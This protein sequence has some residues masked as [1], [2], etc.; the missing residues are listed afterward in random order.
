MQEF[1]T[2]PTSIISELPD[3]KRLAMIDIF[4][5]ADENGHVKVSERE[6]MN[7]WKWGNT[8]VRNFLEYLKE[9]S[10]CKSVT[11]QSQ[12]TLIL[13]NTDFIGIS[14]SRN[15]AET[16]QKQ[17]T[18]KE[19]D[20]EIYKRII[21]HLNDVCGTNYKPTNKTTKEHI[22][23][24]LADGFS[25]ED[26][27]TVIDKKSKEWKNTS[28]ERYLRPQTLFSNK[29]ESY[30]NQK[31]VEDNPKNK[32]NNFS[33]REYNEKEMSDLEKRLLGG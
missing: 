20:T 11:K 24:R 1:V 33:Q 27:Y 15:K 23:A 29:F 10:I 6:L 12:S 9:Q 8:R 31:I 26:F 4:L 17:S 3:D 32:F 2:I 13:I 5:M 18:K 28:Q 7:R 16:K 25:E 30:L 14:Q 22:H 19:E 21:E